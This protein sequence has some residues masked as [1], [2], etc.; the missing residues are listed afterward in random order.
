[1]PAFPTLA[2][3]NM[4]VHRTPVYATKVLTSKSGKEQR[5]KFQATPFYRF[6]ISISFLRETSG[7]GNEMQALL[8]FFLTVKGKWDTFTFTDPYDGTTRTCR[9]DQDE[10]D[11][12][13]I[14]NGVWEVPTLKIKEVK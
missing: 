8:D 11:A 9:L 3:V 14:V 5:A 6:D 7:A 12:G 13:R 4:E 1:M 2:G 10:I